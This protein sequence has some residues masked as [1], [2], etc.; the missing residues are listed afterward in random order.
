MSIIGIMGI[1]EAWG[2]I[3]PLPVPGIGFGQHEGPE[4]A[5][6]E[7]KNG[8]KRGVEEDYRTDASPLIMGCTERK[9]GAE[10]EGWWM[11]VSKWIETN[12]GIGGEM[13][14]GE[15]RGDKAPGIYLP[16]VPE[17]KLWRYNHRGN[18]SEQ[19]ADKH[20]TTSGLNDY[21]QY[22]QSRRDCI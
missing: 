4:N 7:R 21:V 15:K 18:S 3:D 12:G 17:L 13:Q 2:S 6:G 1:S 22:M 14:G 5:V 11:S 16:N 10:E 9:R 19:R 8:V 20:S